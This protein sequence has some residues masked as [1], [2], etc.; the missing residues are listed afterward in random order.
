[1]AV[2]PLFVPNPVGGLVLTIVVT[3]IIIAFGT[4]VGVLMAL[5]SFFDA[6][7]WQEATRPDDTEEED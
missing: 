4:Y 6:S 2:L 1:M 5:Q 3:V 7:A